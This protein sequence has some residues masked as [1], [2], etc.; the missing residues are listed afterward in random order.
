MTG[1][2]AAAGTLFGVGGTM[3]LVVGPAMG[4]ANAIDGTSS[5][6]GW[7]TVG[8]LALTGL[9]CVP[10]VV[11]LGREGPRFHYDQK[12]AQDKVDSYNSAMRETLGVAEE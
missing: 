2:A 5:P 9:A 10:A 7:V 11:A 3:T 6:A 8:G 12:D 4:L 1:V